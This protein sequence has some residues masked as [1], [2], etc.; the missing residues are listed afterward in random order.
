[1]QASRY[2]LDEFHM[3]GNTSSCKE[4]IRTSRSPIWFAMFRAEEAVSNKRSH[5]PQTSSDG[6][7]EAFLV[8]HFD[9]KSLATNNHNSS[10]CEIN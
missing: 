2:D 8:V 10:T 6:F 1:M 9:R 7:M 5:F 3:N 4:I